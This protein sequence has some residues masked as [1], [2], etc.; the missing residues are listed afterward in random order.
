MTGLYIFLAIILFFVL[1]GMIPIRFHIVYGKSLSLY[2]TVL[3]M[4]RIRISPSDKAMLADETLSENE[5]EKLRIRIKKAEEKKKIKARKKQDKKKKKSE[6]ERKKKLAESESGRA[7]K[8][9]EKPKAKEKL[10][11]P[12]ILY[13]VK[14]ALRALKVLFK[15]FGRSLKIRAVRLNIKVASEDAAKTAYM[16]G[17]ISAA[18]SNLMAFLSSNMDFKATKKKEVSVS[19]D[20]LS[21]KPELD[22]HIVLGITVGEVLGMLLGTV[23]AAGVYY[24]KNPMPGK[25]KNMHKV[26]SHQNKKKA[27]KATAKD[28]KEKENS[29]KSAV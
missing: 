10:T 15:K 7:K 6:L 9:E 24:V 5:R 19:A 8:P 26:G 1:I 23:F 14:L 3:G 4:I 27:R 13:L 16:Y 17:A 2:A 21:D 28:S 11:L 25:K 18:L 22:L 20:F 12:A 29:G